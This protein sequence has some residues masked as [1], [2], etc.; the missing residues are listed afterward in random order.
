MNEKH[1]EFIQSVINRMAG[2]SFQIKNW[3][4]LILTGLFVLSGKENNYGMIYIAIV[5]VLFFWL[6][7]GYYLYLERCYRGLYNRCLEG[8]CTDF[9]LD[10]S[11]DKVNISY[12]KTLFRPAVLLIYLASIITILSGACVLNHLKSHGV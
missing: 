1:L 2:N 10:I 4:V 12:F 9:N 7:D 8:D 3:T 6:L 5:P 11:A